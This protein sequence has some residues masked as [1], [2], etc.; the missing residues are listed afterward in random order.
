MRLASLGGLFGP[1]A[2]KKVI[3]SSQEPTSQKDKED[4]PDWPGASLSPTLLT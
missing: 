1:R 4:I 3:K 2:K